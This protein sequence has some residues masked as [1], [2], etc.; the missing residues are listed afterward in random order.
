MDLYL[1]MLSYRTQGYFTPGPANFNPH[2]GSINHKDSPEG[3]HIG[4]NGSFTV[5]CHTSDGEDILSSIFAKYVATLCSEDPLCYTQSTHQQTHY[6]LPWLKV[7]NY[8]KI[9]NNIAPT[10][11]G[12]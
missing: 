4:K 2:E 11:F 7:L 10:C 1:H 9:H 12:L 5:C 6:L 8:I 3:P